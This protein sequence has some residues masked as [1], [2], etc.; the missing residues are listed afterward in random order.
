LVAESFAEQVP[1]DDD[2]PLIHDLRNKHRE[3]FQVIYTQAMLI[4]WHHFWQR[5]LIPILKNEHDVKGLTAH[6]HR[7]SQWKNEDASGALQ[8]WME[9]LSLDWFDGK[10]IASQLG[11]YLSEV[12][13]EKLVDVVPLLD[14]LLSIPRQKH[15]SVGRTVARC[16]SAGVVDDILLWRYVAG[17]IGDDDAV[18]YKFDDKLYCQPHE[19]GNSSNNFFSKRIKESRTLLDMALCSIEQWSLTRASRYGKKR[20]GYRTEFLDEC[21]YKKTRS[22]HD[23]QHISSENILLDAIEAAILNHAQEH[24]TWWQSN[25]ERLCVN[26]EGALRY[27]TILACINT[28]QTNISLVKRLLCD[29]ELL[30][31]DL[32]YELGTLVQAAF[33]YL[34]KLSQDAVMERI[35]KVLYE[36]IG[37]E[38]HPKWVLRKRSELIVCI[39]C[40]LR[41]SETQAMLDD[42]QKEEGI[43]VHQ[44]HIRSMAGV[45]SAPFSFEK[46]LNSSDEAVL[47]L[48]THYSGYVRKHDGFDFLVG[49]ER[50]VG[51]ELR[52]AAS[53]QPA[54]FLRLLSTHWVDIPERNCNDI[55]DGT[56]NYLNHRHGN[57]QV[58]G[59]W[60]PTDEPDA[61]SLAMDILDELERHS[62]HW[63]H[64]KTSSDALQ[65]CAHVIQ[66]RRNAARL[67]FL[68]LGFSDFQEEFYIKEESSDLINTAINLTVGHVAE[69]LMILAERLQEKKVTFP[70]LLSPALCGFA[71]HEHPAIRALII[72]RL[73][74]FQSQNPELGWD[75]FE[76][77][78]QDSTGLWQSAERCLY[79]AYHNRFE[80]VGPLLDRIHSEGSSEDMETWGLISALAALSNRIDFDIWLESCK[81]MDVAEVW[82]GAARVWTNLENIKQHRSQCLTGIGAGL[83]QNCVHAEIIA[84]EI[85]NLFNDIEPNISIPIELI[86]SF[87]AA[88]GSN[89]ENEHDHVFGFSKWLNVI[90]QCDPEEAIAA[91]EIYL[92]YIKHNGTHMYDYDNN[93]TQLMTRLFAEAEEREES[94][95]GEMLQRV[96]SIQDTLLSLGLDSIHDWLKAAERP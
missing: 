47:R 9:V 48:L 14:W 73:P 75:L 90:A 50:E 10:E 79:Y 2:W 68:A 66:D 69:A 29:K 21:S 95:Q 76:R 36:S 41:S 17:D 7:V 34:D 54:R 88:Y 74:Y 85:Y 18:K 45:I 92:A 80:K 6:V 16:V 12:D 94:D 37:A 4:E 52:E 28:P 8:F 25:C 60:A 96:V 81:T 20:E 84:K 5:Y 26:D 46:F 22:K 57:L 32:S 30:E 61:L 63:H 83:N 49:G 51:G 24:S 70:K 89:K 27:F 13:T 11:H 35:L 58:N 59:E 3:V 33:V 65:A 64:N 23:H 44:L 19:F 31:S 42:Y 55:M 91:T 38:K 67:V 39:P 53:R 82:K 72:Q 77:A 78:M 1:Q 43:L 87:F 62:N 93:L 40:Y 86:R 56:S 71:G 15:S